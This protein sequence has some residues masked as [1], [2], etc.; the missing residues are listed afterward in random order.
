MKTAAVPR[1]LWK[2][3]GFPDHRLCVGTPTEREGSATRSVKNQVRSVVLPPGRQ[4]FP[5]SFH[6]WSPKGAFQSRPA[7]WVG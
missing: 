3:P 7:A 4:A 6:L 5:W 1:E 2:T